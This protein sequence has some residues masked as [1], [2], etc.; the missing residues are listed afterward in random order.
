MLYRVVQEA[1]TSVAKP[2]GRGVR[3]TV[4]LVW[5]PGG[6]E[7]P[8]VHSGG[9]G[10]DAGLPSSGSG[11]TGMAGRAALKAGHLEAGHSDGGF[12]VRLWLPAAERV[13]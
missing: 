4:R 10:V 13:S 7:V 6:V 9:D 5:A 1:R 12:A 3:V 11:L 8:V 2:A